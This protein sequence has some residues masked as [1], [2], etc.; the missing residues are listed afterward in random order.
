[1]KIIAKPIK[2]I[3][4][5]SPGKNPRPYKFQYCEENDIESQEIII[6]KINNVDF[7][8]L[9]GIPSLVY[10]CQAQ[11]K[12]FDLKYVINKYEWQLYRM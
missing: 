6:E 5:F 2:V 8:Q 12:L 3:A 9:A 4:V 10:S 1:M 7:Q 11:G